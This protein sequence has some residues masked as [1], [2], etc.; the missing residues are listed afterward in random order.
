V[1]GRVTTHCKSLDALLEGGVEPGI[2]TEVFGPAGSGKTNLCIQLARGRKAAL[3]D[4][5]GV[6]LDRVEQVLGASPD[7]CVARVSSFEEQHTAILKLQLTEPEIV[8]VDSFVML[9]RLAKT[10]D[11]I[12][13]MNAKLAQQAYLLSEIAHRMDIPVV[14]TNQV[15]SPFGED[16]IEPAAG[17]ILKYWPKCILALER[18]GRGTRKAVL[19]K[20][21]SL[22]EL[23]SCEFCITQSGLV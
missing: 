5:E 11:N 1:G 17:D 9:Y 8:L 16:K 10:K 4:T 12:D 23:G 7:L 20:H 18:T 21:R 22:P 13:E 3:I 2:I 6:S 15:Y 19:V 14:V